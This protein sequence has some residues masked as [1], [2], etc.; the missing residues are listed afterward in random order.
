MQHS[1]PKT[2][3][4]VV[5][6]FAVASLAPVVLLVLAILFGGFWTG[7]ALIYMTMMFSYLLDM[8]GHLSTDPE[9]AE[10]EYHAAD[11][12]STVLAVSHFVLLPI[13]VYVLANGALSIGEHVAIFF[14]T[15]LFM[16]QVS[17]SNAHELVHRTDPRLRALGTWV[18]ISILFGH[19]TTAHPKVHH[20]FVA[21]DKDPNSAPKGMS[22]YRFLPHAWIGSFKAGL[23][24]ENAMRK[25]A[26]TKTIH[27]Y[28]I[29]LGGSALCL[30]LA[31]I[32]G[33]FWGLLTYIA[34]SLFA[35]S[36]LMLSDYVQ[37]Y[38]LRRRVLETG[39]FE[40]VGPMHS[41]NS[42]RW[43]S[44]LLMLNAPRHSDHHAHPMTPYIGLTITPDMPL[45][46][47]GLP[48][49]ATLALFPRTWRRVMDRRVDRVMRQIENSSAPSD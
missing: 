31:F 28:A 17:N 27:P 16:G 5:R 25:R 4:H 20:R 41:W 15:G 1:K 19:H 26:K 39:E 9:D 7:A 42:P 12:L 8:M 32:L 23:M 48:T 18:Y 10:T 21:T 47:R 2:S 37:H 34:L 40:P 13:V 11:R 44:S 35:S 45:W 43:F 33:G 29:Y 6:F 30:V 36:Q 3:A 22:F 14:A 38:G 24:V 49:M 46:P